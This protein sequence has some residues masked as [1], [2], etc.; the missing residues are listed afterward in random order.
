MT[1]QVVLELPDILF[2]SVERLATGTRQ[3][4]Q[5][6]LTDILA[7]A[8]TGWGAWSQSVSEMSNEQVLT[9]MDSQ[10]ELEQSERLSELLDRQQAGTLTLN[11]RPELWTL[12]RIYQLGQLQKAEALAEVVTRKLHS[13][14]S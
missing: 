5:G 2:R 13:S 4:V 1:T 11:E 8:L 3:P 12:T 9:L 7:G 14:D 6:V 10:M